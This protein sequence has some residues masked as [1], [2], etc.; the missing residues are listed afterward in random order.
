MPLFSSPLKPGSR[1]LGVEEP[2][3]TQQTRQE[4]QDGDG[5]ELLSQSDEALRLPTSQAQG[6]N[7]SLNISGSVPEQQT[8]ASDSESASAS[9]TG[10]EKG[11]NRPPA[12]TSPMKMS[13]GTI[14]L[15]Q[16]KKSLNLDNLADSSSY[17]SDS[18]SGSESGPEVEA[19]AGKNGAANQ[20]KSWS[21]PVLG[22]FAKA[23]STK[24][25]LTSTP[26][27]SA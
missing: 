12:H 27:S 10:Y 24:P 8:H 21:Q 6:I 5:K 17:E 13:P 7:A 14:Q 23:A 15:T 4:A 1:N 11:N 18:D 3:K 25:M 22:R 26:A 16:S 19:G 2:E 9:E 20:P